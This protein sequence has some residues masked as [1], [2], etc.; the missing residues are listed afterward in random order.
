MKMSVE[1][2]TDTALH[3][4]KEQMSVCV[5]VCVC[6]CVCKC[7]KKTDFEKKLYL[8]N[9]FTVSCFLNVQNQKQEKYSLFINNCTQNIS[10]S[11]HH[12]KK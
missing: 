8:Q 10:T 1:G 4:E 11:L 12:F 2:A 9:H 7:K 5:R 3:R 6:V